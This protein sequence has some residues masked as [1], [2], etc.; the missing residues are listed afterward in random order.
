MSDAVRERIQSWQADPATSSCPV[1]LLAVGHGAVDI[2]SLLAEPLSGLVAAVT[3][4]ETGVAGLDF[5]GGQTVSTLS[6]NL[7]S[8]G[9]ATKA[10]IYVW[11]RVLERCLTS[12][13][14]IHS[15]GRHPLDTDADSFEADLDA[16]SERLDTV[17]S[18]SV[19]GFSCGLEASGH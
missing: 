16:V 19:V 15:T 13:R 9:L 14:S 7:E 6:L 1:T 12:I 17:R 5:S 10:I 18:E 2:W 11:L 8:D 4:D 3:V